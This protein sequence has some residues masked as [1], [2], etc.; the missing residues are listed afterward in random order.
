MVYKT[1]ISD[2]YQR[3]ANGGAQQE[4]KVTNTKIN[5]WEELG[6]DFFSGKIGLF[7]PSTLIRS[8]SLDYRTAETTNYF[9]Q[10]DFFSQ[11]S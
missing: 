3:T 4:I 2:G 5:E 6:F 1:A 9:G 8:Y 11:T 7:E 10:C